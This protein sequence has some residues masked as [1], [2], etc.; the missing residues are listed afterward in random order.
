ML[1]SEPGKLYQQVYMKPDQHNSPAHTILHT[2]AYTIGF[3][4]LHAQGLHEHE[5]RVLSRTKSQVLLDCP[6]FLPLTL[7]QDTLIQ[8]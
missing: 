4:F 1:T 8:R 3:Q 5:G 6:V 2:L 7:P